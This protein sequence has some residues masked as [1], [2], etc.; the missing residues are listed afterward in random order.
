[1]A[2][3]VW[4]IAM[5]VAIGEAYAASSRQTAMASIDDLYDAHQVIAQLCI[6]SGVVVNDELYCRRM[7][8]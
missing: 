5:G 1:M 7:E 6:A 4:T 3:C 2:R 8:V